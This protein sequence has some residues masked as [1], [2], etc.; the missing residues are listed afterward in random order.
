MAATLVESVEKEMSYIEYL[1]NEDLGLVS[2]TDPARMITTLHIETGAYIEHLS[3]ED[4]GLVSKVNPAEMVTI[5]AT[6]VKSVE[7]ELDPENWKQMSIYIEDKGI[8]V[9]GHTDTQSPSLNSDYKPK[10]R[11]IMSRCWKVMSIGIW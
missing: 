3:D 4:L 1:S 9:A 2:E 10:N 8:E 7:K 6:L 5:A 11:N